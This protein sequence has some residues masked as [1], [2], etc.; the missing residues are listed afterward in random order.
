MAAQMVQM[1]VTFPNAAEAWL[2]DTHVGE[3]KQVLRHTSSVE[4]DGSIVTMT[5]PSYWAYL[6]DEDNLIAL[7]G[8]RR[9]FDPMS[10]VR[11]E[12]PAT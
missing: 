1:V 5:W 4:Q 9:E 11:P 12:A 8:L 10:V 3:V 2:R 6:A 7:R